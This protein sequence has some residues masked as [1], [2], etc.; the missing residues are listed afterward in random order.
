MPDKHGL[1]PPCVKSEECLTYRYGQ[2]NSYL[3]IWFGSS[4]RKSPG[5]LKNS[6]WLLARDFDYPSTG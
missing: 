2:K 3:I 5:N 4:A 6:G 1:P